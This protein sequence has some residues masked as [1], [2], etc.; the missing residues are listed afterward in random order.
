MLKLLTA[1]LPG[2]VLTILT[3]HNGPFFPEPHLLLFSGHHS[4]N[5]VPVS[6]NFNLSVYC[7]M[8]LSR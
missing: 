6:Y 5:V 3:P 8:A 1:L 2:R 4:A 7:D